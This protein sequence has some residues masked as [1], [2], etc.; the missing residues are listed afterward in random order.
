MDP[1]AFT[2]ATMRARIG[3]I[4]DPMKGMWRRAVSLG[5]RFAKLG[6]DPT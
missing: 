5:P 4:G 1:A 3:E 2:V 6:L